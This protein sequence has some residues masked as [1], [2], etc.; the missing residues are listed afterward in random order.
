[1]GC[2]AGNAPFLVTSLLVTI[3][4]VTRIGDLF[5][6]NV[7][8]RL[9]YQDFRTILLIFSRFDPICYSSNILPL[10]ET[11]K[12]KS[13]LSRSTNTKLSLGNLKRK[14]KS[15]K[16]NRQTNLKQ[17]GRATTNKS[18]VYNERND[19][20][21]RFLKRKAIIIIIAF[22]FRNLE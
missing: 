8:F 16:E 20:E 15:Q 14:V 13:L 9:E 3:T 12:V 19:E 21:E 4:A 6:S 22:R 7:K 2:L 11:S 17:H 5:V 18:D 10:I 1:M